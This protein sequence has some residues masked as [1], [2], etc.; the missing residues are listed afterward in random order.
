MPMTTLK[1]DEGKRIEQETGARKM[2]N[3]PV[4]VFEVKK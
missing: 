2:R 1:D 3:T 4:F